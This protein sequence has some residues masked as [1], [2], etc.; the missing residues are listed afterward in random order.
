MSKDI[1][2]YLI[3]TNFHRGHFLLTGT[4]I[5]SNANN[6]NREYRKETHFASIKVKCD[7]ALFLTVGELMLTLKDL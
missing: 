6:H 2:V 1:F 7:D 5:S 4:G 3:R